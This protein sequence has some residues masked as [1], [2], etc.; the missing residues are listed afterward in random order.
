MALY[1][2][3][4]L[5]LPGHEGF[6]RGGRF[7]SSSAW[8]EVDLSARDAALL[9]AEPRL[10]VE[11]GGVPK[12]VDRAKAESVALVKELDGKKAELGQAFDEI[13]R[14]ERELGNANGQTS[15]AEQKLA[16]VQAELDEMKAKARADAKALAKAESDAKAA[17]KI[18][19]EKPKA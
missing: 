10:I 3:R 11:L 5:A 2:V 1:R 18:E 15:A 12:N 8:T 9:E 16:S 19:A 4:A 6:R 17:A 13:G 14:L 7:W